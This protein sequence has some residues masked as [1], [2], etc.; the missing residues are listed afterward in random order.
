[1]KQESFR[2]ILLKKM[3]IKEESIPEA[4]IG[5]EFFESISPLFQIRVEPLQKDLY[6]KYRKTGGHNTHVEA[7]VSAPHPEVPKLK[8]HEEFVLTK[9]DLL[10]EDVSVWN[11]FE[12][13][14]GLESCDHIS[15]ST[16][17]KAFRRYAKTHHPDVAT[18]KATLDFAYIV[19][20]K[21]DMMSVFEKHK[22]QLQK[23]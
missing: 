2:E 16:I 20:V 11:L 5:L 12:Q 14:M 17:M 13:I 21:N 19:R 6:K 8:I 22:N 4:R 7:P 18:S 10:S 9:R 3:S 15:R 23:K 1:M